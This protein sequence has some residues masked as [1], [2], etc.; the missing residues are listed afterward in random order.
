MV[1]RSAL[2]I[3]NPAIAV[4]IRAKACASAG[5]YS[6]NRNLPFISGYMI[7]LRVRV[8]T[9]RVVGKEANNEGT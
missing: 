8:E 4:Q 3:Q 9:E 5:H 1:Q 6:F 7:K 2:W